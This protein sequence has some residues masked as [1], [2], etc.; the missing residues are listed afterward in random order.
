MLSFEKAK[1]IID[2]L[3]DLWKEH[4]CRGVHNPVSIGF[5]G[6]EPLL[7]MPL[8]KQVVDYI[9]KKGDIGKK[10][11]FSMTT[12]AMLLDKYMDYLAEKEFRLLISM[13]GDEAAHSYRTDHSGNN[14]FD[15][16]FRNVKLL[17]EKHPEYFDKTVM[18]NSVLHNRNNVT[19]T[20]HFIMEHFNKAPS[21]SPLNNSGIRPDKIEEFRTMYQNK[22]ESINKSGNCEAIETEI[23]LTAPRVSILAH[24]IHFRT[25][26][27]FN[28]YNEL[29]IDHT[30]FEKFATGTCSPFFKKMF[31]TVNGKILQ[32][33]RIDHDFVLGYV[34]NDHVEL[35]CDYVAEKHNHYVS[36]CTIQCDRCANKFRCS[37][38]AY[39]IDDI[40]EEKI[41]CQSLCT[42]KNINERDE[43]I[44][45][46]LR[47]HPYYYEKIL[48]G[49]VIRS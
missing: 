31:V 20:H 19:T 44:M 27:V 9:E 43:E 47:E 16:V 15:R 25:G 45:D 6:G 24:Y 41:H 17:K 21:I 33:E 28:N 23:F 39:Y 12:N 3:F 7:N 14:S 46:F 18:F 36:K 42:Q 13:D 8:I 40:R 4:H 22:T 10:F 37:Q 32:C 30:V 1:L 5:Y 34:H 48:K 29:L 26:N 38:C 49:V 35:D 2:Y 11:F